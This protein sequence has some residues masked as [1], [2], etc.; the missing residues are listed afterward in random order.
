M[1]AT[2]Q[3]ELSGLAEAF[4]ILSRE[5]EDHV[6]K[7]KKNLES[8]RARRQPRKEGKFASEVPAEAS[9]DGGLIPNPTHQEIEDM[10][11]SK[12]LIR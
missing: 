3:V 4:A 1:V 6:E 7:T 11:R 2:L 8:Y 12:G 10:A 9:M 5:Q